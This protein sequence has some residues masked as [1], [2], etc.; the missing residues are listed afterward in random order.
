MDPAAAATL[1]TSAALGAPLLPLPVSEL[2]ATLESAD[3]SRLALSGDSEAPDPAS[4]AMEPANA[5]P[6]AGPA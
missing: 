2:D 6:A 3:A 1:C 4:N 5:Q